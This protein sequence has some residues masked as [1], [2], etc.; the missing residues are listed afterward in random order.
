MMI[1]LLLSLGIC[2]A[3]ITKLNPST[4]LSSQRTVNGF[5]DDRG[6]CQCSVMLPDPTFPADRMEFLEA[7]SYNLSISIQQE[8]TKIHIYQSKL[9]VYMQNVKNLTRRVEFIEKG[10]ASYTDLDFEL[11]KLEIVQ[12][13]SLAG[14]FK[15]FFNGSNKKVEALYLE[16]HNMFTMVTQLE[17]YDKN[18]V[19]AVR[20]EIASLQKRLDECKRN[21]MIIEPSHVEYGTCEHAGIM[22]I[23][24][25]LVVQLNW[26][27]FGYT[28]GGWGKDSVFG[29][30]E[31]L[32]WVAPLEGSTYFSNVRIYPT[33]VDLV[34]YKNAKDRPVSGS[35]N[36]GGMILYNNS[37]YYNC[38]QSRDICKFNMATNKIVRKT[39]PNAA[40]NNR[41]PYSSSQ[42][43]DID[44]AGDEYGVWVIYSTESDAGNA[45]IGKLN[46]TSLELIKTWT[47][48]MYKPSLTNAFMVCGV[49]YATRALNTRQEEIFY[50]YDTSTSKESYVS[51]K[52]DKM[53]EKIQSMSYNP[54]DQKLYTYNDGYEVTYDLSFKYLS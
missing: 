18:N 7:S 38:Y 10:S 22:N 28:A 4:S 50:M 35:G 34:L 13:E 31:E 54:N 26:R 44:M 16:I 41:F 47:T 2:Q 36:G 25:P 3:Q 48:S 17:T 29:S 33:Y 23:S 27:G 37:L 53:M 39:L 19:L 5:L 11:L 20:R 15:S 52:F 6:V 14:E 49:M 40:Y 1:L 8:L 42:Y 46:K 21:D 51:I 12:L 24:R 32:Y 30:A 45:I 9:D 43:Q